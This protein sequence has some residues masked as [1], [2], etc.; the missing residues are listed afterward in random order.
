M[1]AHFDLQMFPNINVE[2]LFVWTGE[3]VGRRK[4]AS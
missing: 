2:W 3:D 1:Y 4:K